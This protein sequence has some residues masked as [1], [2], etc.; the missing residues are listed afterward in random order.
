MNFEEFRNWVKDGIKE[1]SIIRDELKASYG[2]VDRDLEM[3]MVRAAI[4][5][6][7]LAKSSQQAT[8]SKDQ[9]SNQQGSGNQKT[10]R[11]LSDKQ[12][13]IIDEHLNGKIGVQVSALINKS[14]KPLD[15]L[16]IQEASDI[17]E[18]IFAG[19]KA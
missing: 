12:K 13:A 5:P 14:G 8:G 16:S 7:G 17:I 15:Q 10:Y 2:N 1:V 4:Q 18:F 19:G 3:I 9:G 6:W 11:R